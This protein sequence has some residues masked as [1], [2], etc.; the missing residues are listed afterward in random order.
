MIPFPFTLMRGSPGTVYSL[1]G[2]SVDDAGD[3]N[4]ETIITQLTINMDGTVDKLEGV[5]TTQM[6]PSTDWVT[7]STVPGLVDH[8]VRFTQVSGSTPTTD[9]HTL[10]TWAKVSGS[11]SANRYIRYSV[12][13]RTVRQGEF[14]VEIATDASGVSVVATGTYFMT[15]DG[16]P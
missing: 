7:P 9:G 16:T 13:S 15:A 12:S 5:T 1:L 6:S 3:G 10:G 8:W 14:T 4:F 2:G 11:G